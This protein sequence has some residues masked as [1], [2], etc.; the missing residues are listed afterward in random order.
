[1]PHIGPTS[2]SP[3]AFSWLFCEFDF[4]QFWNRPTI[5]LERKMI[6]KILVHFSH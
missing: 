6:E 3:E 2:A 4:A 1:M 5:A